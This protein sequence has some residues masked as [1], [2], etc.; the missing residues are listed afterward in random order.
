MAEH[1]RQMLKYRRQKTNFF[2]DP[3]VLCIVSCDAFDLVI[4]FNKNR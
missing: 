2:L 1:R 4:S 3:N